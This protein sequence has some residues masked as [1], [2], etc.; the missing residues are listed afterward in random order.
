VNVS[1]PLLDD[2]EAAHPWMFPET[3]MTPP[4][5]T[6]AGLMTNVK[7]WQVRFRSMIDS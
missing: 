7:I 6:V 2:A 4:P 1:N 5:L 3:L